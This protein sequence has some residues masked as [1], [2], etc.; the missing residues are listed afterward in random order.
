MWA[1]LEWP[2]WSGIGALVGVAALV[3]VVVAVVD[4]LLR[5]R[6][7]AP[8]AVAFTI[9]NGGVVTNGWVD[10]LVTARIMGPRV[11]YEPAARV[12][13]AAYLDLPRVE[14]VLDAR[15]ERVEIPLRLKADAVDGM[16]VGLVWVDP[17]RRRSQAGGSRV[18]LMD[19]RYE[20]WEP[21]RWQVWPR[22]SA[23][24]WKR[25]RGARGPHPLLIP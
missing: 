17:R 21:Y 2:G 8:R 14:A 9:D 6:D 11:V 4:F 3:A 19:H 20:Y 18:H 15:S 7:V 10:I 25:P 22:R 16:W 1:W 23:G 13:G 12:W 24:R 5:Q